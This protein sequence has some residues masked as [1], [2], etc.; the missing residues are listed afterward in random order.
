MLVPHLISADNNG[1]GL[2]NFNP[3]KASSFFASGEIRVRSD[4]SSLIVYSLKHRKSKPFYNVRRL[5]FLGAFLDCNDDI[6]KQIPFM[7]K[8]PIS[9]LECAQA[10]VY[11]SMEKKW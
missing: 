1:F 2:K 3:N 6:V 10:S 5:F 8:V 7:E 4:K 11:R 9:V